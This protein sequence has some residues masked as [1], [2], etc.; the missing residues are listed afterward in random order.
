MA[1]N[2]SH[3]H[4]V[5][6]SVLRAVRLGSALGRQSYKMDLPEKR[7]KTG[8]QEGPQ[9]HRPAG[10]PSGMVPTPTAPPIAKRN[11]EDIYRGNLKLINI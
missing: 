1:V 2:G 9:V 10:T 7:K 8:F 3:N 5:H 6:H 4:S 11:R